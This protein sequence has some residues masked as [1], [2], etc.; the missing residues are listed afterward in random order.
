MGGIDAGK[1]MAKADEVRLQLA[2]AA[3]DRENRVRLLAKLSGEPAAERGRARG[4]GE[5]AAA[6]P[7]RVADA[8]VKPRRRGGAFLLL[9]LFR[10]FACHPDLES[11]RLPR[12]GCGLSGAAARRQAATTLAGALPVRSAI[13]QGVR[14]R[15]SVEDGAV[16]LRARTAANVVRTLAT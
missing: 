16:G 7:A 4:I 8:A 9:L 12:R 6:V 14:G 1:L 2:I 10:R 13:G 15:E 11:R 5:I 3:A